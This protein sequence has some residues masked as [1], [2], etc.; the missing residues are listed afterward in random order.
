MRRGSLSVADLALWFDRPY[1]TVRSWAQWD[2][3]PRGPRV[4]IIEKNLCVL[5]NLIKR[6]QGLPVP[7]NIGHYDRPKYIRR[8]RNGRHRK[9]SRP[10]ASRKRT[11]MRV[12]STAQ[13]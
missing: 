4:L 12:R 8:L 10:G 2:T 13:S 1:H 7:A 9:I 6:R 5:E 3:K 11:A